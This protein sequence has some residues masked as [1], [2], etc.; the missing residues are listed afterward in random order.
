MSEVEVEPFR[1]S[2]AV[3]GAGARRG[4]KLHGVLGLLA[5]RIWSRWVWPVRGHKAPKRSGCN[6]LPASPPGRGLDGAPSARRSEVL[7]YPRLPSQAAWAFHGHAFERIATLTT[8]WHVVSSPFPAVSARGMGP[9]VARGAPGST[10]AGPPG[11]APIAAGVAA[12]CR[13]GHPPCSVATACA[14]TRDTD[15][16]AASVADRPHA[17][18]RDEDRDGDTVIAWD[19]ACLRAKDYHRTTMHEVS[20]RCDEEGG[21]LL[22]SQWNPRASV[23]VC[24]AS[25]SGRDELWPNSAATSS[26]LA[27]T[28]ANYGSEGQGFKSSWAR[29]VPQT[30]G[31]RRTAGNRPVI[32]L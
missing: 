24:S 20:R 18:P 2:Q 32:E 28:V 8:I 6:F 26:D 22:E 11:S 13:R 23:S 30:L 1:A 16:T 5:F 17:S 9:Q 14:I 4:W 27:I 7:G 31:P 21:K 3:V 12:G 15:I 29:Q 10:G 19:V 25:P